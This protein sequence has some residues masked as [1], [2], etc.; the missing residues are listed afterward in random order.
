MWKFEKEKVKGFYLMS[1]F[2]SKSL[3]TFL[4][5]DKKL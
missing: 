4:R 1:N 5:P 2:T 3:W